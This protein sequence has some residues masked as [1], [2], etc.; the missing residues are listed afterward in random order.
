MFRPSSDLSAAQKRRVVAAAALLVVLAVAALGATGQFQEQR[1]D[2]E[3]TV[4]NSSDPTNI[5]RATHLTVRVHNQEE[6]A[7]QPEFQTVHGQ[8]LTHFYWDRLSGPE[9]LQP[10]ESAVYRLRAPVATAAIPYETRA[11]LAVNDE[12]VDDQLRTVFSLDRRAPPA[13]LNPSLRHWLV[14]SGSGEYPYR[15]ATTETNRAGVETVVTSTANRSG[16]RI[17]VRGVD[18]ASGTWSMARLHQQSTFPATLHVEATPQTVVQNTPGQGPPP[19]AVG[20]GVRES[21][22]RVW[23]VFADVENRTVVHQPGDPAYLFVYVPAEP[24]ERTTATVDVRALYQRYEWDVPAREQWIVDG[25]SYERR[26]ARTFAFAAVYPGNGTQN[27]SLVVHELSAR[28]A[29]ATANGSAESTARRPVDSAT[30]PA[31]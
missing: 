24:G 10:G 15:W 2:A 22:H 14:R 25:I 29:N 3:V 23:V 8:L 6:R 28:Q 12:G 20:V 9:T 19:R 1:L 11:V 13:I 27:A 4:V 17:A 16:A 30:E 5:H 18:R 26:P 31:N 21:D 7:I